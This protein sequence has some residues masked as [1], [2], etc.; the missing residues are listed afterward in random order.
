M[1]ENEVPDAGISET[2]EAVGPLRHQSVCLAVN[3]S[4][5]SIT[6]R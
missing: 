5:V 6:E 4:T 2:E 1:C 3:D